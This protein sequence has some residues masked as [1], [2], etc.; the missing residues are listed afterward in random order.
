MTFLKTA[1]KLL[2][3]VLSIVSMV[4]GVMQYFSRPRPE[5]TMEISSN[6]VLTDLA[7]SFSGF[8]VLYGGEDL[9]KLGRHARAM[10]VRISNTGD[11]D[12]APAM[13]DPAL[14]WGF[15]VRDSRVASLTVR[16]TG[17]AYLDK[18]LTGTLTEGEECVRFPTLVLDRGQAFSL[19]L[20]VIHPRNTEP[21]MAPFG[22]FAGGRIVLLSAQRDR[23]PGRLSSAFLGPVSV[24]LLRTV[25]YTL[26]SVLGVVLIIVVGTGYSSLSERKRNRSKLLRNR[27]LEQTKLPKF[28]GRASALRVYRERGLSGLEGLAELVGEGETLSRYFTLLQADSRYRTAVKALASTEDTEAWRRQTLL[29]KGR[30]LEVEPT[31]RMDG[32]A[33]YP[34]YLLGSPPEFYSV[35]RSLVDGGCISLEQGAVT[36]SAEFRAGLAEATRLL[37]LAERGNG[38]R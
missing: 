32:G 38:G 31:I 29:R 37:S 7:P 21:S 19:D 5:V 25:G 23:A 15:C 16:Q 20:I 3:T 26:V 4:F 17:D 6:A 1:A 28:P 24:Q 18:T 13:L 27:L 22:K 14:G 36:V 34:Q 30:G 9:S 8:T 33:V 11:V 10:T 2:F 12:I 35:F